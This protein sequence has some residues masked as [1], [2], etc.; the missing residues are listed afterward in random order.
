M[1]PLEKERR[2]FW[3]LNRGYSPSQAAREIGVSDNW[4]QKTLRDYGHANITAYREWVRNG[5]PK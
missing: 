3:L 1:T 4:I 5:K 2:M